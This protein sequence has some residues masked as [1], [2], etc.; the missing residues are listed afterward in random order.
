MAYDE[1]IHQIPR[2]NERELYELPEIQ[3]GEVDLPQSFL[4]GALKLQKV[5]S[6]RPIE[7]FVQDSME[8]GRLVV[9]KESHPI[10][11]SNGEHTVAWCR[12]CDADADTDR[13][14]I[15]CDHVGEMGDEAL[16]DEL[17]LACEGVKEA[18]MIRSDVVQERLGNRQ[19]LANARE[20]YGGRR[21]LVRFILAY[22]QNQPHNWLASHRSD[23]GLIDGFAALMDISS[24]KMRKT[25]E[26]M[27]IEGDIDII[28]PS[29]QIVKPVPLAT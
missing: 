23:V 26:L 11:T 16:K 13:Y 18:I 6:S 15:I 1:T 7:M 9:V 20:N 12:I 2:F 8:N 29:Q 3:S 14:Q 25:A 22:A 27:A 24:D 10:P 21:G 4:D 28:G 5:Q 17:L 19:V